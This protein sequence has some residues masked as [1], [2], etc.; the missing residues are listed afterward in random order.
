MRYEILG[1]LRVVHDGGER[2]IRAEKLAVVLAVLLIRAEQVVTAEQLMTEI[3]GEQ[4]P[5]RA[6]AGVQVHVSRLRKL[7][8]HCGQP[9]NA[10][11]TRSG[12]YILHAMGSELDVEAFHRLLALGRRSTAEGLHAD[13]SACFERA[14]GLWRGPALGGLSAGPIVHGFRKRLSEERIECTEM[15]VDCQLELSRH[16]ELVAPLS[17][18]IAEHPFR[19]KFHWQLM[20]ALHRSNR[21]DDALRT[22]ESARRTFD[23]ELGLEPG[24][25]LRELHQAVLMSR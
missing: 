6:G 22:Y 20:L 9:E 7:L 14:L 17:S 24:H 8:Q 25:K 3:W 1:P 19:E 16:H 18:L 23:R 4:L 15:L 13:A 10:I 11:V 12:G 5:Q 2:P 21:R